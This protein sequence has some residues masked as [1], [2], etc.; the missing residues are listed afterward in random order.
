MTRPDLRLADPEKDWDAILTGAADFAGHV[1]RP[2]IIP[3]PASPEFEGAVRFLVGLPG[4]SVLLA[5]VDGCVMGG[6]GYLIGPSTWNRERVAWEEFFFWAYA[7]APF[8]TAKLLLDKA[9]ANGKEKGATLNTAHALHSSPAGVDRAYR[10]LGMLPVQ[11]TYM[12][13][14]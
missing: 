2:D 9:Y 12:G 5:V 3:D 10:R 7:E 1:N 14:A 6:I 8:G 4:F 13:A 11:T